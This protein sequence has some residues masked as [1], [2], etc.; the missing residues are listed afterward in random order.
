MFLV[1]AQLKK[2]VSSRKV[3]ELRLKRHFG[4][5]WKLKPFCVRVQIIG[6]TITGNRRCS[7]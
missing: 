7:V 2:G 5:I 1:E 6:K 3:S 4:R